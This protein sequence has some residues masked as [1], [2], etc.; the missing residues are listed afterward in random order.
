[1][2]SPRPRL[3]GPAGL[4]ALYDAALHN[5]LDVNVT[6][7][8]FVRAGGG[9]DD[10]WTRDA[11]INCW[12][13][14]SLLAPDVARATLLKVC[15][16]DRGVVAQDNQWWDQI[17]WVIGAWEH[18]AVTG[19]TEFAATAYEI[20]RASL[21]ILDRERFDPATGLYAGPALMQDGISGLP[22]YEEVPSS[23][24]QG[25]SFVLDYPGT[26]ELRCLSTN[27]VYV[28]A[29]R[30]LALLGGEPLFDRRA[31]VLTDAINLHLWDASTGLYGYYL[32][33]DGLDRH[34]ETAGLALAIDFGIA[35]PVR[36]RQILAAAHRE[37]YGMVNVWPHFPRYDAARPGRHNAICWP[38]VMGLWGAAAA[39]AGDVEV[40]GQTLDD[41]SR[42]FHG[43]G[44][45]LFELYNAVTG[46]VDGGW[47][48]GRQWESLPHQTW[49]ATAYL[50]LIHESLFG[51]HFT[52]DGITIRPT[53]PAGLGDL[54]LRGLPYRAATL[55]LTLTGTGT[56]AQLHLD[57]HPVTAVPATLTGHHTLT[58][59][60]E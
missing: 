8:G 7:A 30:C 24:E 33:P 57:G 47:Q 34:Q 36:T 55:D 56:T 35:G 48:V 58:I 41:L 31:D 54:H 28:R 40:F 4:S 46:A 19:D 37:P 26:A 16:L 60:V 17:I 3:E 13:A 5:L 12:N 53:V 18:V 11:A 27:A 25:G 1:V 32:G 10:P 59:R 6:A 2:S 22:S 44:D 51:L 14:A 52:P 23:D 50:R 9:Y 43:S 29:L 38:M 21:A 49:S 42:L 45:E 39:S 15:D 20:G